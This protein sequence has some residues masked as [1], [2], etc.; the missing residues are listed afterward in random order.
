M[1][2]T[3]K[4]VSMIALAV[5]IVPGLLFFAGALEIEP[6]KWISLGGTV[7]WFIATPMWMGRDKAT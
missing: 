7:A 6:M 1:N 4:M 5:T 3:A 2:A